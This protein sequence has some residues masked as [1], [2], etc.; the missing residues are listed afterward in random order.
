MV[1]FCEKLRTRIWIC[2]LQYWR[3]HLPPV[4]LFLVCMCLCMQISEVDFLDS[5]LALGFSEELNQLLLQVTSNH[6]DSSDMIWAL[7]DFMQSVCWTVHCTLAECVRVFVAAVPAAPQSD[8]QYFES[9]AFQPTL[10]PQPRVETGC[11]GVCVHV[12]SRC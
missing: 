6:F 5:V 10:L 4:S 1:P 9:A 12:H 2:V 3:C 7:L 11:T 8:P